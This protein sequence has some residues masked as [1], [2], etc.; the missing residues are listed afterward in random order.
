[1]LEVWSTWLCDW[2]PVTASQPIY[3]PYRD[4]SVLARVRGVRSVER[5]VEEMRLA[6]DGT[7]E[8][9]NDPTSILMCPGDVEVESPST[10]HAS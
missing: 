4:Y 9:L 7:S 6:H 8:A 2:R 3:V 10:E 5:V 1:M